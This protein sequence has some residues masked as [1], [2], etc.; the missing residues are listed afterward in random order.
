MKK[1]PPTAALALRVVMLIGLTFVGLCIVCSPSDRAFADPPASTATNCGVVTASSGA[2]VD[3]PPAVATSST[4]P[5]DSGQAATGLDV[6]RLVVVAVLLGG[7]GLLLI[8]SA[9]LRRRRR[10]GILGCAAVGLL[11]AHLV[12]PSSQASAASIC[13][14]P[15]VVLPETPLGILL[16]FAAL[17]IFVAAYV[18]AGRR[19]A[20]S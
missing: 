16:P 12:V 13:S 14:S 15:P 20:H 2:S 18:W 4:A 6:E 8:F 7:S 5:S 11:I 9:R 10:P 19:S 17:F 1:N 3:S